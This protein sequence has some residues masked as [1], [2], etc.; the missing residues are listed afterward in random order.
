MTT[1]FVHSALDRA[2]ETAIRQACRSE[3]LFCQAL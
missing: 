3:Q 1:P 2:L